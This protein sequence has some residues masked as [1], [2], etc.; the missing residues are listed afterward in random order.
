MQCVGTRLTLSWV[1]M[2]SPLLVFGV[3]LLLCTWRLRIKHRN[4]L[5]W[6]YIYIHDVL[7]GWGREIVW[8]GATLCKLPVVALVSGTFS[9]MLGIGGGMINGPLLLH[10]GVN[11]QV[12]SATTGFMLMFTAGSTSIQYIIGGELP[13]EWAALFGAVGYTAGVVGST[14]ECMGAPHP[15]PPRLHA[16]AHPPP[17]TAK[18]ARL[19]VPDLH[20]HLR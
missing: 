18:R 17:A 11:S 5:A 13:L 15:S 8:E 10:L 12:S 6:K 19:T 16:H 9:G 3:V 20:L 2:A 1:W 7:P 4:R 14:G